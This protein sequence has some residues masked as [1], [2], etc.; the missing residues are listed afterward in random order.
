MTEAFP[1]QWPAHRKRFSYPGRASFK[2]TFEGARRY[3]S[4]ELKLLGATH[5]VISTNIPLRLD[6]FPYAGASKPADRGVAVYFQYKGKQMC[7]ACDRWDQ[8]E[9]NLQAI[10]HTISALRGIARWGTGDMLEAAFSGFLALPAPEEK[11]WWRI[12]S[13]R[14]DAPLDEI[15]Q[16][17]RD[18][19]KRA[20]PD[21]GGSA[22]I[23]AELSAAIKQARKEKA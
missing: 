9:H 12:F 22:E 16:I 1:L 23:M 6:G 10:G 8:V 17:Y 7:F 13:V 19:A 18:M 15:E 20:H 3:L 2:T 4:N 11:G 21:A 14:R 5:Q